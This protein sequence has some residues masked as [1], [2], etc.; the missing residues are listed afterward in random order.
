MG[1]EITG[2]ELEWIKIMTQI[3]ETERQLHAL[4][5]KLRTIK[6]QVLEV[7]GYRGARDELLTARIVEKSHEKVL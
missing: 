4:K 5:D 7:Y 3:F 6:P 1:Q 2:V